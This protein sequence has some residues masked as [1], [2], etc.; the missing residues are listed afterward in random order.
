VL[1]ID[2]PAIRIFQALRIK[3]VSSNMDVPRD[4]LPNEEDVVI[5]CDSDDDDKQEMNRRHHVNRV[6]R[7][8]APRKKNQEPEVIDLVD[9]DDEDDGDHDHGPQSMAEYAARHGDRKRCS[10]DPY[11]VRSSAISANAKH[12]S[13]SWASKIQ[14]IPSTAETLLQQRIES[15]LHRKTKLVQPLEPTPQFLVAGNDSLENLLSIAADQ[16]TAVSASGTSNSDTQ[17]ISLSTNDMTQT[18]VPNRPAP[19]FVDVSQTRTPEANLMAQSTFNGPATSKTPAASAQL[20][21]TPTNDPSTLAGPKCAPPTSVPT[22]SSQLPLEAKRRD[23]VSR[24]CPPNETK[25]PQIVQKAPL[26]SKSA[27]K[28][29]QLI[30]PGASEIVIQPALDPAGIG[31]V[32]S[33][34]AVSSDLSQSK[35]LQSPPNSDGGNDA[36]NATGSLYPARCSKMKNLREQYRCDFCKI[37]VFKDRGEAC[38]HEAICSQL[39]DESRLQQID[40]CSIAGPPAKYRSILDRAMAAAGEGSSM[41]IDQV[42]NESRGALQGRDCTDP[43]SD[44][45]IVLGRNQSGTTSLVDARSRAVGLSLKESAG[46]NE[47]P[48]N[49]QAKHESELV[50]VISRAQENG[51]PD[52]NDEYEETI[53]QL[54]SEFHAA[55]SDRQQTIIDIIV[56]RFRFLDGQCCDLT[57]EQ[58]NVKVTKDFLSLVTSFD[59]LETGDSA[60]T[61]RQLLDTNT[62]FSALTRRPELDKPLVVGGKANRGKFAHNE[63]IAMARRLKPEYDDAGAERQKDIVMNIVESFRFETAA[64]ARLSLDQAIEKV[65]A[66]LNR[67]VGFQNYNHYSLL[68]LRNVRSASDL[69]SVCQVVAK[70]LSKQ[71]SEGDVMFRSSSEQET[72]PQSIRVTKQSSSEKSSAEGIFDNLPN[73]I[74]SQSQTGR[75]PCCFPFNETES[76]LSALTDSS[77]SVNGNGVSAVTKSSQKRDSF[78]LGG[79][80]CHQQESKRTRLVVPP[81]G[82]SGRPAMCLVC[83]GCKQECCGQCEYC[84]ARKGPVLPVSRCAFRLC[85]NYKP[86]TMNNH[87]RLQAK[88]RTLEEKS[89]GLPL[90]QSDQSQRTD[91]VSSASFSDQEK[92]ADSSVGESNVELGWWEGNGIS[93]SRM[94]SFSYLKMQPC[95]NCPAC[96]QKACEKCGLCQFGPF[97]PALCVLRCCHNADKMAKKLYLDEICAMLLRSERCIR[98]GT[99]VFCRW[100]HNDSYYWGTIEKKYNLRG[101]MFRVQFDDGDVLKYAPLKEM[102]DEYEKMLMLERDRLEGRCGNCFNC[103]RDDCGTCAVCRDE[104]NRTQYLVQSTSCVQKVR[105]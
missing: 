65:F 32:A 22:L 6:K 57:E 10:A 34:I 92:D 41:H 44:T 91:C 90:A 96:E 67:M 42:A 87:L 98:V 78:A 27:E 18:S 83:D 4:V 85:Q 100:P 82:R 94:T 20:M 58:A 29:T 33:A 15:V 43:V 48:Q 77:S 68:V 21:H 95:D 105:A 74:A 89:S 14:N 46:G 54:R 101:G 80:D 76:T 24:K 35:I 81:T 2:F 84:V 37:K 73:K 47:T 5:L 1:D 38:A 30:P 31:S 69:G 17:K 104:V 79:K 11:W 60:F 40:E 66:C 12:R 9:S 45:R 62:K 25:V 7:E 50:R 36:M 56:E 75:V 88:V 72:Y 99:R 16:R 86:A 39:Y 51:L 28:P 55:N 93:R 103:K 19:K 61:D 23:G 26:I 49:L 71:R 13:L 63:Y 52:N 97:S 8:F 3:R 59:G 102:V 53:V 70:A 64:R